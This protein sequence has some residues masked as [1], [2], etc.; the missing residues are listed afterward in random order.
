VVL[1]A[2]FTGAAYRGCASSAAKAVG[3]FVETFYAIFVQ[4]LEWVV[5]II[6]LPCFW[7]RRMWWQNRD[8][9][10]KYLWLFCA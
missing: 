3:Q 2:L 6:P 10:F 1:L 7:S 8:W 4:M 9:G 5:E